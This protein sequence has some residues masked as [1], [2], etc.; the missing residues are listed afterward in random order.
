M[1]QGEQISLYDL[2]L[3]SGKMSLEPSQVMGG[4]TSESSSKRP[5]ELSL[6]TP[7]F[8]DCRAERVGLMQGPFWET[9]GLSLGGY[10]RRSFGVYPNAVVESRLSQILEEHPHPRYCLSEKACRGILT[11]A[12]RRHK[13]LP[14]LLREALVR[15]SRFKSGGGKPGGGKSL[16]FSPKP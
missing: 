7:Q 2:G 11:R 4:K 13:E 12:E 8:L 10:T 5:Q 16:V 1:S 14:T 9:D 15:Q 6:P 3:W